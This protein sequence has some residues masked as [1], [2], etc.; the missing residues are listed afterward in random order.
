MQHLTI[1]VVTGGF[2]LSYTEAKGD[3]YDI[4]REV[5]TSQSKLTKRV[6]ELLDGYAGTE[7]KDGE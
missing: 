6:K 7:A 4:Q 3:S 2:L 1:E 5:F